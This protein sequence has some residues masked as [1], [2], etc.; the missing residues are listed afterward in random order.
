MK[1]ERKGTQRQDREQ[2]QNGRRKTKEEDIKS[3]R[4]DRQKDRNGVFQ[5]RHKQRQ[6]QTTE[7]QVN[8]VCEET[9]KYKK[10]RTT[11]T[12]KTPAKKHRIKDMSI[13]QERK[14]DRKNEGQKY[15]I[16]C[17]F[18]MGSRHSVG[19]FLSFQDKGA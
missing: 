12:C 6:Q 15:N 16:I 4:K 11:H 8:D 14:D 9:Q 17:F 13:K 5:E 1:K 18:M 19:S 7:R 10:E 2:R 3:V